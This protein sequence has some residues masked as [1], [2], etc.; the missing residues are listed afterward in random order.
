MAHCRYEGPQ[1]ALVR[2]SALTLKLLAHFH[3]GAVVA[4]PTSSLPEVIGG[5][6][7]W[8]YRYAWVR[9]AALAVYALHRIGYSA[10]A[11]GFLGWVLDAVGASRPRSALMPSSKVTAAPVRCTGVT[12]PRPSART[13]CTASG[14]WTTWPGSGACGK[15]WTCTIPFAR[16]RGRSVFSPSRSTLRA[17]PFWAIIPRPSAIPGLSRA[18]SGSNVLSVANA[19]RPYNN[20]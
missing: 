13:C 17:A 9:D 1:K 5:Q 3:K 12:R 16:E 11:A 10:E 19:A 15:P 14:W 4:A 20:R 6:R 8:D 2:R 18:A 7:N